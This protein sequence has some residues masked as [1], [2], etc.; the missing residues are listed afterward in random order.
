MHLQVPGGLL[1][2]GEV[3][4]GYVPSEIKRDPASRRVARQDDVA[5]I[6]PDLV[7]EMMVTCDGIDERRGEGVRRLERKSGRKAILECRYAEVGRKEPLTGVTPPCASG[8]L[9]EP[10]NAILGEKT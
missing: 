2:S 9:C 5:G 1:E 7:D 3:R 4:D 10:N 6:E 8:C